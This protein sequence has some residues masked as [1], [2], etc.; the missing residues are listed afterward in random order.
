MM[1]DLS[2]LDVNVI[3]FIISLETK[4]IVPHTILQTCICMGYG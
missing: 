3:N 2:R 1:H 4:Q